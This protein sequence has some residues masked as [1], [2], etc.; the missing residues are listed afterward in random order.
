MT[1]A[2]AA[3]AAVGTTLGG[4]GDINLTYRAYDVFTGWTL[5]ANTEPPWASAFANV[6]VDYSEFRSATALYTGALAGVTAS[7]IALGSVMSHLI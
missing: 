4:W 5:D 3:S 2:L 6:I 7:A 1:P